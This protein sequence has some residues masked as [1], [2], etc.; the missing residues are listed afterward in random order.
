LNALLA[1]PAMLAFLLVAAVP[2]LWLDGG[3][4][5]LDFAWKHPALLAAV[6]ATWTANGYWLARRLAEI[7]LLRRS[8]A[9]VRI[10]A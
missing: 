1:V 6:A 2:I 9:K 7:V 8:G 3:K 4:A 5:Y 10:D